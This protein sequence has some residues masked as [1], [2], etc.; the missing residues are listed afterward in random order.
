ME[1]E[2]VKLGYGRPPPKRWLRAL[3]VVACFAC[4]ATAGY[5][6]WLKPNWPQIEAWYAMH[7]CLRYA[8]PA[9]E[10]AGQPRCWM[11]LN[12]VEPGMYSPPSGFNVPYLHERRM[13]DGSRRLVVVTVHVGE[14]N[15]RPPPDLLNPFHMKTKEELEFERSPDKRP[16]YMVQFHVQALRT[17]GWEFR[18]LNGWEDDIRNIWYMGLANHFR[19]CNGQS[20]SE[21]PSHFT[22]EYDMDAAKGT[23]DGW[24]MD[25]GT[26]ELKVRDGPA[27]EWIGNPSAS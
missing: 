2:P 7:Q 20:D 15:R 21:D 4:A 14:D 27:A 10:P 22:I 11:T 3:V 1:Q 23:I 9:N 26:V 16:A 8:A 6:I 17:E 13:A 25:D 5:R 19:L 24:L 18:L 12:R